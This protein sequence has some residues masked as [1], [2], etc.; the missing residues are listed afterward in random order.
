MD[1]KL[2]SDYEPQGDQGNAAVDVGLGV[3]GP[4]RQGLMVARQGLVKLPLLAQDVTQVVVDLGEIG[5]Q[6]QGAFIASTGVVEPSQFA[7]N[8]AEIEIQA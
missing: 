1:F 6:L 2:V 4:Q 5:P 7:E 8:E 3:S